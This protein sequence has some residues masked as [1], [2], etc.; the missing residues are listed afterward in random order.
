M[1]KANNNKGIKKVT[2]EKIKRKKTLPGPSCH[3]SA[4]DRKDMACLG[5]ITV[6]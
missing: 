6:S 2:E 4:P 3:F 1:E 5:N